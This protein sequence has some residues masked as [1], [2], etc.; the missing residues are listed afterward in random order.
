MAFYHKYPYTDFHELNLDWFLAEF[1]KVMDATASLDQTVQQFTEFVTN[2][3][4]NLDVQQ[5]VNNKLEQMKD[6]GELTAMLWPL[7][8]DFRSEIEGQMQ[9]Q[10][11]QIT[12]TEDRMNTLEA[13]M[14]T[15]TNL[16]NASTAG[17]AELQDIRIGADGYTYSNAGA[18]V[19]AQLDNITDAFHDASATFTNGKYI[20]PANG[21]EVSYGV[22][23]DTGY[24]DLAADE[25][26][27]AKK[28]LCV[29]TFTNS[30][31]AGVA[32]YDADKNFISAVPG[33]SGTMAQL[34]V[35]TDTV[36]TARYIRVS[37]GVS[38]NATISVVPATMQRDG[39]RFKLFRR[40]S[41]NLF[42]YESAD[43]LTDKF[44]QA[45]QTIITLA[46]FA[47]SHPIPVMKGAAYKFNT[48]SVSMGVNCWLSYCDASGALTK[49]F[50]IAISGDNT[51]TFTADRNGYIRFN[52]AEN[53]WCPWK[54][55]RFATA[56]VYNGFV[57]GK[58]TG[59]TILY[60][61]DSICES[62]FGGWTDNGGAFAAMI[63]DKTAG[64]YINYSE[65]GATLADYSGTPHNV[66]ND[67]VNMDAYADAVCI[68]AGV[69]DYWHGI[70]LGTYNP[71]DYTGAVNVSTV[72]G[73]LEKIFRDCINKWVGAAIFFVIEHQ[74]SGT[75][76]QNS[77]GYTFNDMRKR[78]IEICNKYGIPY[79][80]MYAEGG[81]NGNIAALDAAFLNGGAGTHPDGCHPDAKGYATYYVPRVLA[82]LEEIV[83]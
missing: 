9:E 83:K 14:D 80:D 22:F 77:A 6:D 18:A 43:I 74:I 48:S 2:Y 5:E 19:R 79:V 55:V 38:Y 54:S 63:A 62:R 23:K 72:T 3:F 60:N 32:F 31:A 67:I 4:D 59:K 73:A 10:D 13:R 1:K 52:I 20:D 21:N 17:D 78:I 82:K 8:Q 27:L 50:S 81:L 39:E 76:V 71:T 41:G 11:Q 46:G 15:F 65:S 49:S 33:G 66:V 64:H 47:I 44:I 26:K 24:I 61:G 36:P 40:T 12:D 75:N 68:C 42:D 34:T 28:K 7:L 35:F 58:L 25:L 57:P 37:C 30:A 70:Q 51:V 16:P 53:A 69:N 56:E 45:N 29:V